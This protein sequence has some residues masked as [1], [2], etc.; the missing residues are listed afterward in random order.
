MF[1]PFRSGQSAFS[2]PSPS[3]TLSLKSQRRR[4]RWSPQA[5]FRNL[6]VGGYGSLRV[7]GR[8]S[9]GYRYIYAWH[10]GF[11]FLNFVISSQSGDD[12]QEEDL[13]KI[14]LQAKYESKTSKT[15]IHF[16]ATCIEET[17][18]FIFKIFW[19]MAIG[20]PKRHLIFLVHYILYIA[21]WL[22]F[23]YRPLLLWLFFFCVVG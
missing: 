10:Q 20:N 1:S 2:P 12:P 3:R 23:S 17:W 6:S 18:R 8:V 9:N 4:Q 19:I 7:S 14:W 22:C 21:F 15:L 11:F 16:L 13:A 5:P